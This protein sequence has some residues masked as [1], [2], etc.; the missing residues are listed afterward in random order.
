MDENDGDILPSASGILHC[1]RVLADE[2]ATLK[3][4]RTMIALEDAM[5]MVAFETGRDT[6]NDMVPGGASQLVLH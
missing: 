1:L 3:L 5:T 2:A 6:T 4:I